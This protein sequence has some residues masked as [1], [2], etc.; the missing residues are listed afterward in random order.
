MLAR[1][2]PTLFF[3][4]RAKLAVSLEKRH[5]KLLTAFA[6]HARARGWG[7]QRFEHTGKDGEPIITKAYTVVSP[8]DWPD[9]TNR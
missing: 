7:V 6:D 9:N 8:D 3:H 1:Q 4:A 5:F 2:T